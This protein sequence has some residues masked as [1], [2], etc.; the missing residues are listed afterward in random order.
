MIDKFALTFLVKK[1]VQIGVRRSAKIYAAEGIRFSIT[2]D[3]INRV[4]EVVAI[5]TLRA[6]IWAIFSDLLLTMA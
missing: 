3:L 5:I 1:S 4:L 2:T 6:R